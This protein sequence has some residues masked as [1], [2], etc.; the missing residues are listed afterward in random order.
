MR[1]GGGTVLAVTCDHTKDG[2]Q[3]RRR[4][5]DSPWTVS[6]AALPVTVL[7]SKERWRLGPT[8]KLNG[9]RWRYTPKGSRHCPRACRSLSSMAALGGSRQPDGRHSGV[10]GEAAGSTKQPAVRRCFHQAAV[11][12]AQRWLGTY[13]ETTWSGRACVRRGEGGVCSATASSDSAVGAG[14]LGPHG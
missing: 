5:A 13:P 4:S 12:Q 14:R 3:V 11:W 2:K 1:H 9:E 8:L 7:V 10:W 6:G